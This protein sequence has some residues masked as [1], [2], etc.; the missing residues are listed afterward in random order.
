MMDGEQNVLREGLETPG[1]FHRSRVHKQAPCVAEKDTEIHQEIVP[2]QPPRF[3]KISNHGTMAS[4]KMGIAYQLQGGQAK[5][6][7]IH[8]DTTVIDIGRVGLVKGLTKLFENVSRRLAFRTGKEVTSRSRGI[9]PH[10]KDPGARKPETGSNDLASRTSLKEPWGHPGVLKLE[11]RTNGL[12]SRIFQKEALL[13]AMGVEG[14]IL[15]NSVQ[16]KPQLANRRHW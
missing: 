10:R 3:L 2:R 15:Q 12:A 8:A 9:R 7:R 4:Q 5:R 1:H 11:A 6:K 16:G 14:H 13:H